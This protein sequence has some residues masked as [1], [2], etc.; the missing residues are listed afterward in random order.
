MPPSTLRRTL[1]TGNVGKN[2]ICGKLLT[3]K[4]DKLQNK[5]KHQKPQP[6]KPSYK[7]NGKRRFHL[8]LSKA[9]KHLPGGFINGV[10][11]TLVSGN[12]VNLPLCRLGAYFFCHFLERCEAVS[13]VYELYV[14][15]GNHAFFCLN[16]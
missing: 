14:R 10:C 15:Q 11:V 7:Q 13:G 9:C 12:D 8:E 6:H 3:I 1:N 5:S 2:G 4:S 16:M